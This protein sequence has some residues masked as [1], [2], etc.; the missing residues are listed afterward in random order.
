MPVNKLTMYV[1]KYMYSYE[2]K[3]YHG[4][5][6]ENTTVLLSSLFYNNFTPKFTPKL[7]T[8]VVRY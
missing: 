6:I 5:L 1:S 8:V 4:V 7:R 3:L 2:I